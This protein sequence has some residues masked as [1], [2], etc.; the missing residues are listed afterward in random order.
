MKVYI[1]ERAIE[2]EDSLSTVR[3]T[4][5]LGVFAAMRTAA[6]SVS[7]ANGLWQTDLVDESGRRMIA[8]VD[9]DL[10]LEVWVTEH[11]VAGGPS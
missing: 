11:E 2:D 8:T 6:R 5:V 1:V 9:A 3:G 10:D 7:A 4:E